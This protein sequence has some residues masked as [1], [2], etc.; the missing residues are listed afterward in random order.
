MTKK[1][2]DKISFSELKASLKS[3]FFMTGVFLAILFWFIDPIIDSKIL[4][5]IPFKESFLNPSAHEIYMRS[6]ISIVILIYSYITALIFQKSKNQHNELTRI[7]SL[8]N[9]VVSSSSDMI[10]VKDKNLKTV[11]CNEVFAKYLGKPPEEFYGKTDIENGWDPKFVLGNPESGIRGYMQDDKDALSGKMIRVVNEPVGINNEVRFY[12]TIKTPIQ[13]DDGEIIGLLG[14]SRD[15][16][17]RMQSERALQYSEERYRKLIEATTSIIWTTDESGSFVTTQPSWEK[18]TGQS[19]EEYKDFGWTKALH[20]EDVDYLLENWKEACEKKSYFENRGRIWNEYL[21]E[22]RDFK[23]SATPIIDPDGSLREWVGV[24]HDIT[25][26]KQAE[27]ALRES[28]EK[29]RAIYESTD[30]GIA[31]CNMD[32]TIVEMNKGFLN[33]I[34]YSEDEAQQLSYWDL[35]PEKYKVHEQQQLDSLNQTGKYG[36]YEKEYIHKNG[37]RI[38][39][40]LNGMTIDDSNGEKR[41]WSIVQ[42]ISQLKE[43][44]HTIR[45]SN[46]RFKASFNNAPIGMAL[47]SLE[48]SIIE[49]NQSLYNMLGYKPGEL[50]GI[51]FKDI[52]HQDDVN[53]SIEQHQK[54]IENVIDHYNFEK[55]YIHKDGHEVWGALSV[56]LIQDDNNAPLY[57]IAQIQDIT[58]RKEASE[59]LSYQASHDALTGLVNRREFERRSERLLSTIHNEKEGQ[60]A[61]CFMDL[62]QFKIV[63]DNCGHTAGD[64]M[65]RQ[66]SSVLQGVVRHRDT[67]ARLGGDEFGVLM[68]YCSLDDAHR[69][70][71]SLQ[72]AIQDYIFSWEGHTFKVGVSIG[73]V[74]ITETVPSLNE[75]LKEADAACY[76]AKDKGRNRIHIYHAEDSELVKRHGEMQWVERLYKALDNDLFCLY[77]QSIIPLNSNKETHYELLIRMVNENGETVPPNA[78][79]PAA[80]RYNLISRID[81]WVIEKTFSLL[82]ENKQFFKKINFCSINLSGASLSDSSILEYIISKLNEYKIDGNK[83]CFEITETAA[84]LNLK[85]ATSFISTLKGLGCH[86]ALDDFGSGLSSFAYLKNLPVDYLKIDGMFVKDIVDDPIDHAM[87]KSINEIGQVMNM[88][89]IAEFVEN[90]V[91]KGM[92]KEIGVDYAQ[93]YGIEK[94]RPFE[95]ILQQ[96]KNVIDIKKNKG[97]A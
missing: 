60:H 61:L 90:D 5:E 65:L 29:F 36:P 18:Y 57:A 66:I 94:P 58:E 19:W 52:T 71:T 43:M 1:I 70:A 21:Q 30:V 76:M 17:E 55:R 33:I 72:K 8:F 84:I 34:G 3:W 63:N 28:E 74:P 79:L 97:S 67:L 41:I 68:E 82:N 95:E 87:V 27:M 73:L 48:H 26:Q 39:V 77:A 56:S 91:I 88:Q 16:T 38:P 75:L 22:W 81:L 59:L 7:S 20:P 45:E 13:N 89:T 10:F 47:V 32:G 54:L 37:N 64:E 35:T 44:E 51:Y 80:E 31:M 4:N 42:D 40:L 83:I 62:D 46:E 9:K 86:F 15:I 85:N 53:I 92:L 23:V 25:Q 69:V 11:F 14:V 6:I 50:T 78:F 96:S 93:G 12:D 49:A 2:K 24:I